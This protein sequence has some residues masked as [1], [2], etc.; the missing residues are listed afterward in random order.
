MSVRS[1]IRLLSIP[2]LAIGFLAGALEA[3]ACVCVE[4]PACHL[5]L[6]ADAVFVGT[7]VDIEEP[8]KAR[9]KEDPGRGF[10]ARIRVEEVFRG[11]E[12]TVGSEVLVDGQTHTSCSYV[13]E[14][15]TRYVIYASTKAGGFRVHYC[16][17]TKPVEVAEKDLQ[18]LRG[19]ATAPLTGGVYGEMRVWQQNELLK[20]ARI[21][22]IGQGIMRETETDEKG[23]YEIRDLTPGEYSLEVKP[24]GKYR[25]TSVKVKVVPHACQRMNFYGRGKGIIAESEI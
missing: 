8:L 6:Y 10:R 2:L 4:T 19:L 24:T 18:F 5:V 1:H 17:G 20:G 13:F 12:D 7:V 3:E 15:G 22:L 23:N 9:G 25:G 16:T 11:L 21:I 14:K